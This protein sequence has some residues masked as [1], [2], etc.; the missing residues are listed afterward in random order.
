MK[1]LKILRAFSERYRDFIKVNWHRVKLKLIKPIDL[2][3]LK[4]LRKRCGDILLTEF[5]KLTQM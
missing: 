3:T 5:K 4:F 2:L 1:S